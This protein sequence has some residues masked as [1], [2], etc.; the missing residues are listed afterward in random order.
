MRC[1][2][3]LSVARQSDNEI[4]CEISIFCYFLLTKT[5]SCDII[6]AIIQERWINIYYGI[7]HK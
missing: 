2:I 6:V 4:F 5:K 3:Y 7:R 1:G